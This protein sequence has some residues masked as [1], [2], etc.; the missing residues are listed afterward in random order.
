[1]NFCQAIKGIRVLTSEP[2]DCID[3]AGPG[4]LH[5]PGYNLERQ[6]AER[7]ESHSK[8]IRGKILSHKLPTRKFMAFSAIQKPCEKFLMAA[9]R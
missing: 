5:R 6:P 8:K 1:M 7:V 4:I 2:E 3:F 9:D